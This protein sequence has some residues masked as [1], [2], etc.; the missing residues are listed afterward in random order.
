M[1]D[2]YVVFLY[3]CSYVATISYCQIYPLGQPYYISK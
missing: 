2:L 3:W 1:K